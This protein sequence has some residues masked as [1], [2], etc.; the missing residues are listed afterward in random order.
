[1]AHTQARDL[2]AFCAT[3]PSA[4][5]VT[6]VLQAGGFALTFYMDAVASGCADVPLL[7]AQYHYRD[8]RG[9]E[10]IYLAG[11]AV[12]PDG[13]QLPEHAS[14]FWIHAGADAG[15]VLRVAHVLAVTWSLTWQPVSPAR[16]DVAWPA[17]HLAHRT[18]NERWHR[19]TLPESL[20][21][22]IATGGFLCRKWE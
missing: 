21:G 9:N 3:C 1:M 12:D 17:T 20:A 5:E 19:T 15:A 22:A 16:Q 6:G 10:L 13:A 4:E 11:W 2:E 8:G 14:R 18:D 7:P